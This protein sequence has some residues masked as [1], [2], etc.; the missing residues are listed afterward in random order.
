[1]VLLKAWPKSTSSLTKKQ[2]ELKTNPSDP[3][4]N[5]NVSEGELALYR[6]WHILGDKK[7]KPPIK[8]LLP[9]SRS[10]FYAGIKSGIY[11]APVKYSK[12]MSFWRAKD[13]NDLLNSI[14][15]KKK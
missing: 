14:G 6:I 12:R 4:D 13:I 10:S 9:I 7:A 3:P 8:P 15:K 5:Q 11:P 1:M 2:S